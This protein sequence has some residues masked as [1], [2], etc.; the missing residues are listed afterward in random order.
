[1]NATMN[2]IRAEL[3]KSFRKRRFYVLAVLYWFLLPVLALITAVIVN[4][5]LS[6]SFANDGGTVEQALQLFA[7]PLGLVRLALMGPALMSPTA[8]I[9]GIA[10]FAGLLFGEERSQHMWKTTLAVQPNRFAVVLGKVVVGM[11]LLGALLLGALLASILA[12]A[13]GTMFLPTNFG[14]EW[15]SVLGLYPLQFLYLLAG[16]L[17]AYLLIFLVRSGTLG[18]IMVIFLPALL[19]G[20]YVLL[21]ALGNLQPLTRFNALFQALRLQQVWEDLPRYFFT[22]NL[23]APARNPL[24]SLIASFGAPAGTDMGPMNAFLGNNIT[25]AHA[26]LVMAGYALVFG[27]LLTWSFLHRDV[28]QRC[29]SDECQRRDRRPTSRARPPHPGA[30]RCHG[31][32]DSAPRA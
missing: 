11:L 6:G 9:I 26:G 16:L 13:I 23:Y 19:E 30:R 31:H 18:I 24:Q 15:G 7:S 20:V 10:L 1:M 29:A 12:G 32:D 21:T 2:V 8:Y 14:G 27:A 22:S 25:L 28:D 4:A 17:L 3:F 5:N